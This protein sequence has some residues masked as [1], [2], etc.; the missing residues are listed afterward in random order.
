MVSI[1]FMYDSLGLLKPLTE[2]PEV[3]RN[4]RLNATLE[5]S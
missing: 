2:S 1:N 5:L 4:R 3:S